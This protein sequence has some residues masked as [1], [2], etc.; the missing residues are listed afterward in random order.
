MNWCA[1]ISPPC[2]GQS[3]GGR[4]K[5]MMTATMRSPKMVELPGF[6]KRMCSAVVFRDSGRSYRDARG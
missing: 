3:G 1:L 6:E 4:M 5:I 2:S